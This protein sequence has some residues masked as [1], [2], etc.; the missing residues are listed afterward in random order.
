MRRTVR[1][2]GPPP[3]ES[4]RTHVLTKPKNS[5]QSPK[6]LTPPQIHP[7]TLEIL[8]RPT[9]GE[10]DKHKPRT[11]AAI[12]KREA[13]KFRM[14]EIICNGWSVRV[15]EGCG[16]S[17]AVYLGIMLNALHYHRVN[18]QL[19]LIDHSVAIADVWPDYPR[20]VPAEVVNPTAGRLA[21]S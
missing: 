20:S 2:E 5:V 1:V 16:E 13:V 21:E 14:S 11:P 15:L 19:A 12:P 8:R 6:Y 10:E 17:E 7:R 4:R 3:I 18:H 9:F